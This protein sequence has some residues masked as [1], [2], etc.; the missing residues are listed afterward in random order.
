MSDILEYF[1]Y[2]EHSNKTELDLSVA[3]VSVVNLIQIS[4]S[5]SEGSLGEREW[6]EGAYSLSYRT[7]RLSLV[8]CPPSTFS[9][10]FFSETTG[11]IV[12]DFL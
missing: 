10:D 7:G 9:N 12:A 3:L 1:L 2:D 4:S 11:L 6:V 8:S 5:L